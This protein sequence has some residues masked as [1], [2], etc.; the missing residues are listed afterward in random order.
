VPGVRLLSGQVLGLVGFGEIARPMARYAKAFQMRTLYWDRVRFAELEADY[1]VTYAEWEVLF[2]QADVISLHLPIT[3]ETTRL[4]GARE[5]GWMKPTA[6][7]INTARGKLVDQAALVEA[8]R[9]R[10]LGGAALD[11]MWDE[12]LPVDDPL[13]ALHADPDANLSLTA[14]TAWQGPWTWVRDSLN[15]WLN[16]RRHL[17]GEPLEYRVA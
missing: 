3:P 8:L 9:G 13:H 5:F 11:V 10:R 7:F 15:I 14:H 17:R 6:L 2:R 12:P 1:D 16:V 4:V